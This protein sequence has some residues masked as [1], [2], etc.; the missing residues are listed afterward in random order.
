MASLPQEAEDDA[1]GHVRG[2]ATGLQTLAGELSGLIYSSPVP[3]CHCDRNVTHGAGID[4]SG[5]RGQEAA[6]LVRFNAQVVDR[7]TTEDGSQYLHL[8]LDAE[9]GRDPAR[10]IDA[11]FLF[12]SGADPAACL[13]SCFGPHPQQS[14]NA[15]EARR[16]TPCG[17]LALQLCM[18]MG[19]TPAKHAC[20]MRR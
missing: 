3:P 4:C 13:R 18:Q 14:P 16:M 17:R 12:L 5:L 19:T 6:G 7:H 8:T 2:R 11:E 9:S 20:C 1:P 15:D 10:I